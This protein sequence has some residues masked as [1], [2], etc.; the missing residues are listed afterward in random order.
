MNTL[1]NMRLQKY[2][3]L[4][5]SAYSHRH[6][7]NELT[8]LSFRNGHHHMFVSLQLQQFHFMGVLK[9]TEVRITIAAIPFYASYKRGGRRN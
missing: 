4:Q 5:C 1:Y 7:F 6:I 2:Y 3:K 8:F 9:G